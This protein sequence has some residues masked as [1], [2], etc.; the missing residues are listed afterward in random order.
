VKELFNLEKE[1]V[2]SLAAI[3]RL[4]ESEEGVKLGLK[5]YQ[6]PKMYQHSNRLVSCFLYAP[7]DEQKG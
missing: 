1:K 2:R 7:H 4:D 5:H 3:D 6:A